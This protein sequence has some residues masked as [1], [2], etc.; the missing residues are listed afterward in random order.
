MTG[1][2]ALDPVRLR[3]VAALWKK[4]NRELH[5]RFDGNSMRPTIEPGQEVL[6]RCTDDVSI[7]DV[8]VYIY[9]DRV[10]VHR[11]IAQT[12]RWLLTRGD[13]HLIPDRPLQ[14]R[15]AIIGRIEGVGPAPRSLLRAASLAVARVAGVFGVRAMS[16]ALAAMHAFRGVRPS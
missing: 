3:G 4:T 9:L 11:L 13:A 16:A 5:V 10:V 12:P 7:G 15:A 14:D 8:I 1:E 2:G 6:L